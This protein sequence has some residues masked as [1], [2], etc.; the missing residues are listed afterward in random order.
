MR[1]TLHIG[2][3][4]TGTTTIQ[5]FLDRNRR[6]LQSEQHIVVTRRFGIG[7]SRDLATYAIRDDY[8]NE[9]HLMEL[10]IATVDAKNEFKAHVSLELS[11][12]VAESARS[13]RLVLSSEHFQSRL[14]SVAEVAALRA[15]FDAN[16]FSVDLVV[17]YMRDPVEVIQSMYSTALRVGAAVEPPTSAN[18]PHWNHICDYRATIERWSAAFPNALVLPRLF[19]PELFPNKSLIADFCAAVGIKLV[20]RTHIPSALNVGLTEEGQELLREVNLSAPWLREPRHRRLRDEIVRHV[21]ERFARAS[22]RPQ[23]SLVNSCADTFSDSNEWVRSRYFPDR[24]SLFELQPR[25]VQAPRASSSSAM[26]DSRKWIKR[27][28]DR[29]R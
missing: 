14:K 29:A 23:E 6:S 8:F 4:K 22:P 20:R 16:G 21:D 15:L 3:E 7:N 24:I 10:G 2:V 19:I 28:L 1:T 5:A 13:D 27:R 11:R 18:N 25:S 26:N 9:D 17:V 12:L